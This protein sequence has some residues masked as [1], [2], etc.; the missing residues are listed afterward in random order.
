MALRDR[1]MHDA[2]A[3]LLSEERPSARRPI[4]HVVA[5]GAAATCALAVAGLCVAELGGA[6]SSG[7]RKTVLLG[8]RQQQLAYDGPYDTPPVTWYF[9]AS[10]N[11]NTLGYT[12]NEAQAKP[13]PCPLLSP[14]SL[15]PFTLHPSPLT[16]LL[17]SPLPFPLSSAPYFL[18]LTTRA[19]STQMQTPTVTYGPGVPTNNGIAYTTADTVGYDFGDVTSAYPM[20]GNADY[21]STTTWANV[22]DKPQSDLIYQYTGYKTGN[23]R[24]GRSQGLKGGARA[25][26]LADIESSAALNRAMVQED[27][28]GVVGGLA[29]K[30][31]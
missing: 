7:E 18:H 23:A 26:S 14:S 20:G 1:E 31:R 10:N 3:P 9:P 27:A 5:L 30:L 11:Q 22:G 15:P 21:Q 16:P 19:P 29:A 6:G 25:Q 28:G 17:S 4:H 24:R 13:P 8:A 12:W 2:D